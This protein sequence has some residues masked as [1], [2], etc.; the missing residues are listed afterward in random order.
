V[1][2][3]SIPAPALAKFDLNFRF[4]FLNN[5]PGSFSLVLTDASGRTANIDFSKEGVAN[6]KFPLPLGTGQFEEAYLKA[7]GARI[8]V[9]V[10]ES[11]EF[12]KL[13]EVP[14][15]N[16]LAG[17]NFQA[18][19]GVE[20]AVSNI[21]LSDPVP[22]KAFPV[23][24]HF[25]AWKSLTRKSAGSLSV[26]AGTVVD[27]NPGTVGQTFG[28]RMKLTPAG[29]PEA[30]LQWSNGETDVWKIPVAGYSDTLMAPV[31][32]RKKGEKFEFSLKPGWQTVQGVPMNVAGGSDSADVGI[33]KQGKGNWALE[34]E[35]YLARS[36]LDG[37]P[38]AIHFRLPAAP[39]IRAYVLCAL[40]PSPAKD[41]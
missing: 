32:G 21:V 4:A 17:F 22:M 31:A 29:E 28:I 20:F 38:S 26:E 12:K 41:A 39:Y 40:D 15:P 1:Y 24:Q 35:E 13:C 11:R 14:F 36:P 8:A 6:V 34:V 33:C 27:L 2:K 18:F 19:A 25:A 30:T 5:T 23:E 7:D 16:R 9:Y 10:T 3:D 37:F